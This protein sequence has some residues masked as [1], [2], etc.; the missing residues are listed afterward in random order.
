M[1]HIIWSPQAIDD[2]DAIC[3]YI[4]RD[5]PQY[6][7]VVAE[8]II[9]VVELIPMH[10]LAGSV[11][12]EFGSDELRERFLHNFRIIYRIRKDWID[13]VTICHG[14]RLLPSELNE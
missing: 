8:R 2:L 5:S 4:S 11:V 1:A 13:L 9:N 3:E 6:A 10:P 7:S 14:S 12:P